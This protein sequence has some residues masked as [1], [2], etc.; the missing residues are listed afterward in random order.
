MANQDPKTGEPFPESID[1]DI[2]LE[3]TD[4]ERKLVSG[5]LEPPAADG[6]YLQITKIEKGERTNSWLR[7]GQNARF[8]LRDG[9]SSPS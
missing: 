8:L 6:L 2:M 4:G 7:L 1:G 9:E 3:F 5:L